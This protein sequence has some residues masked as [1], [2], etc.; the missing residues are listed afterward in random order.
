VVDLETDFA[1]TED[2]PR[3][4]R[5]AANQ[6]LYAARHGSVWLQGAE[7]ARKTGIMV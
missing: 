3:T 4:V 6:R 5:E 7:L 2:R 1:R